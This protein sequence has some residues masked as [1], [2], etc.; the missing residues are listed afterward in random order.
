MLCLGPCRRLLGTLGSELR[1]RAPF[2]PVTSA[3]KNS[4]SPTRGRLYA[5]AQRPA[6]LQEPAHS[7]QEESA[8]VIH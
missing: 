2:G 7:F 5:G 8:L 4:S 6:G 3:P 1:R